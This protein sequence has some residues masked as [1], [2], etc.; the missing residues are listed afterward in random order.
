[1]ERKLITFPELR[2]RAEIDLIG[3]TIEFCVKGVI[4]RAEIDD[5]FWWSNYPKQFNT[6]DTRRWSEAQ[7]DW[8]SSNTVYLWFP[9]NC[10]EWFFGPYEMPDGEIIFMTNSESF[11]TIYPTHH[12]LPDIPRNEASYKEFRSEIEAAPS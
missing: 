6:L 9:K 4:C 2:A 8:K 12:A 10:G 3:G 1:M 5:I 7:Q 11:I